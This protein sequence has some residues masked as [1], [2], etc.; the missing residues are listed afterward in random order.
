MEV[1]TELGA[2]DPYFAYRVQADTERRIKNLTWTNGSSRLQHTFFEDLHSSYVWA[3]Q[4]YPI[5]MCGI[6]SWRVGEEQVI[7]CDTHIGGAE[8]K[9]VQ[10]ILQGYD[11]WWWGRVRLQMWPICSYGLLYSHVLKV[12][13]LVRLGGTC[14]R[15]RPA[16]CIVHGQSSGDA[17]LRWVERWTRIAS[18]FRSFQMSRNW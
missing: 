12:M 2:N 6:P 11:A 1:F 7:C 8:G 15:I 9:V 10:G 3:V 4:T 14:G 13:E 16:K 5:Q 17:N 18:I